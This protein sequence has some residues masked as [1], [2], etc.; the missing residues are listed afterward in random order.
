MGKL[1]TR[2]SRGVR[3]WGECTAMTGLVVVAPTPA[4]EAP[5]LT[6]GGR[7]VRTPPGGDTAST[8]NNVSTKY[9]KIM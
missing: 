6:T 2:L 4:T 3:W 7:F 1:N 9:A 8:N 5:G